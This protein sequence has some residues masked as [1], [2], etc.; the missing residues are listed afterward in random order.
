MSPSEMS[1]KIVVAG[2]EQ[3]CTR[4]AI[5]QKGWGD[6]SGRGFEK[7]GRVYCCEGCAGNSGCT[8]QAVVGSEPQPDYSDQLEDQ[9]GPEAIPEAP[10]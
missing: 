8:C 3:V 7:D 5:P 1:G 2:E 9:R 4:C 6:N 10:L